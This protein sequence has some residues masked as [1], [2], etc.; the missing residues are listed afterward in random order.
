MFDRSNTIKLQMI[1]KDEYFYWAI[2]TLLTHYGELRSRGLARFKFSYL[3]GERKIN[4]FSEMFPS[5]PKGGELFETY[6]LHD[7]QYRREILHATTIVMY[8][9]ET[10]IK[11]LIDYLKSI[12]PIPISKGVVPRFNYRIDENLFFSVEG[13]NQYKFDIPGVVPLEYQKMLSDPAKYADYNEFSRYI[14]GHDVLYGSHP[15]NI[16]S[17][18]HLFQ[19]QTSFRDVYESVGLLEEYH[20]IWEKLHLPPILDIT[21]GKRWKMRKRKTRRNY[22]K[23]VRSLSKRIHENKLGK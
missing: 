4:H 14:S 11:P 16:R 1:L 5:L 3:L 8:L 2:F 10:N 19:T 20:S 12:F 15:N 9:K 23:G 7:K 13:H 22:V 17:Y 21:G 18:H 6:N